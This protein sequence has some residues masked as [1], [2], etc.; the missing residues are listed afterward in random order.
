M[1]NDRNSNS[2]R[3]RRGSD[4]KRSATILYNY[5]LGFV[6]V[7]DPKSNRI[8]KVSISEVFNKGVK[9]RNFFYSRDEWN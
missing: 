9:Y 5:L 7:R 8:K 1:R 6:F 3:V 4:N 2:K